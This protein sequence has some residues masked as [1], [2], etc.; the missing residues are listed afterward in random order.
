MEIKLYNIVAIV[1]EGYASY[2]IDSAKLKGARG[3]TVI[4]ANSSASGEATKLYGLGV[5]PVKDIVLILV[6]E[7]LVNPILEFLYDKLGSESDA[8]GIFFTLPVTHASENL[9]RQ[10]TNKKKEE[11]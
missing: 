5:S 9:L 2:V 6:K 1:N 4:P 11:F 7:E 8:M 3:G 10:Y